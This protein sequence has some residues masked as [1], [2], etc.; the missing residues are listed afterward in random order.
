MGGK[1][2]K[3]TR[4]A[5]GIYEDIYGFAIPIRKKEHRYP[6]GTPLEQLRKERKTLLEDAGPA[7]GRR[8]TLRADCDEHLKT[9]P[10]GRAQN[11]QAAIC[12]HWCAAFGESRAT[13]SL[14]ARDI[15]QQRAAWQ[16]ARR[17]SAKHLNNMLHV[18]R[19]VI[20]TTYPDARN[21]AADVAVLTVTY[22]D[23]RAIP[24]A[25]VDLILD[26]MADT[27]WPPTKD[28]PHPPPNKA[29]LRLRVMRETGLSQAMI[30]RV[31]RHHLNVTAKTVYT[32]MRRKGR[33]V[34]GKTISLTDAGAR[35]FRALVH[36][37]ALGHFSSRS[38][39][40]AWRRA[41]MRARRTW[42]QT[43]ATKTRPR[44]WPLAA[45]ARA[46]DLRHTF[47][48]A[49]ILNTGDL[50]AVATLM[51][52]ANLNTTR[53]YLQAASDARARGAVR[54]MNRG[55]RLP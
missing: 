20:R 18:L 5:T 26:G 39:A 27:A 33:G 28:S 16:S 50:E 14:T 43:E 7:P 15:R 36:A 34:E 37:D 22:T 32:E 25:I 42:E 1:R 4:R 23:A 48:T 8:G 38:L 30:K 46:Y 53:R 40:Q 2:P 54:A 11:E 51:R 29:K 6:L 12:G 9:L 17:F 45:D 44:P 13:L 24:D 31:Q 3:R 35:A 10:E 47:G 49:A 19:A 52:H 41:V 55:G 21:S